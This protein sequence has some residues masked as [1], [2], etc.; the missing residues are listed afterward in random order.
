MIDPATVLITVPTLDGRIEAATS[1]G[2]FQVGM[3][4]MAAAYA[5]LPGNSHIPMARNLIAHSFLKTEFQWLV[6][7]DADIGFST[8]DFA[9]LM[10]YARNPPPPINQELHDAATLA[11]FQVKMP[12]KKTGTWRT[13]LMVA[14]EYARKED[15]APPA[16]LGLGFARIHRSVFDHLRALDKEGSPGEARVDSFQYR[17]EQVYDY[18]LSGCIE[19]SWL[20]EDHGF[21]SLC[22]LADIH[23]RVEQRC[24]LTHTGKKVYTYSPTGA[25]AC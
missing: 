23:P 14:A 24:N 6:C 3:A 25:V 11:S 21:F 7:I 10:D 18:Y 1:A 2:L 5:V 19:H 16:R 4:H 13:P 22:R 15:G 9:I 12:G 8:D 17:G 20:T